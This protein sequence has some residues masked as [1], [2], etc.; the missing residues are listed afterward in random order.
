MRGL[1]DGEVPIDIGAQKAWNIVESALELAMGALELHE[2]G[3][4]V[5]AGGEPRRRGLDGFT[6]LEQRNE[7]Q[8][9]RAEARRQA[10]LDKAPNPDQGTLI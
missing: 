10:A 3:V 5:V 7:A 2:I 1:G 4:V 6:H 8:L 9:L